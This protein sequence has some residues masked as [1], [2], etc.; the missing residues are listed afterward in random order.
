MKQTELSIV[1]KQTLGKVQ[2][3]LNKDA[4]KKWLKPCQPISLDDNTFTLGT[5][6]DFF[7][8]WIKG[9]Y[10][11]LIEAALTD[12]TGS[13]R[14]LQLQTIDIP[15]AEPVREDTPHMEK[16][17]QD[18]LI[19]EDTPSMGTSSG[20]S[21]YGTSEI[22]PGDAST[23]NPRYT[24][25][26]FVMGKSNQMAHA[27]AMGVAE[28]PGL[29]YNPFFLLGGVGLGKTH[30]MHAIGN[31][32]LASFPDR[33]V[34][35]VS[36]EDFTN[37]LILAIR[38]GTQEVFRQRY[39]T[40][41]VL[42]IDDIQF[43]AGKEGTQEEFFHTFNTLFN[44]QKQIIISSD[45]P[46]KELGELQERLISRFTSGLTADIQAPDLETRVAILKK[47][48]QLDR[49]QVP[50]DVMVYIA[51][52]IDSNI[53]ELEGALTRAVAF[54]SLTKQTI[55]VDVAAEALKNI[56]PGGND[57][58]LTI[59]LIQEVVAGFYK[60]KMEDLSAKK[61]TRQIAFPRQIAMYLCRELMDASLPQIGQAFGGRDHSTVIHACEKIA[62]EQEKDRGLQADISK[63]KER[64]ER[65]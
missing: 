18:T 49:L 37:Q 54:S 6:N 34:L 47:K 39:R 63:I 8:E 11:P 7:K 12:I 57:K 32:I 3:S 53:R 5:P 29:R 24:F 65:A 62:K 43:L 25:E 1:W 31:R 42:L 10:V 19:K 38:G 41:D 35:Y 22:A 59:E 60:V 48:A 16:P 64:L 40:I 55:T 13:R 28:S 56:F 33:R 27:A 30:L 45:R 14:A 52:R 46:P 26:N 50:D 36:S 15:L 17:I 21:L 9:R 61:R 2:E 23:L 20:E 58:P 4:C 44:A 51:S